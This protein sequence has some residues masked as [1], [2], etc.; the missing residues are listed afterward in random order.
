MPQ[1]GE[2]AAFSSVF[3]GLTLMRRLLSGGIK[4]ILAIAALSTMAHWAMRVQ[5]TGGNAAPVVASIPEPSTTGSIAPAREAA[6]APRAAEAA[7]P[8]YDQRH[9]ASLIATAGAGAA[10]VALT[11]KTAK[12]AKAAVAKR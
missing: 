9:L 12:P 10:V 7:A 11:P 4:A 1:A 5:R 8:G 3:S 6:S 2:P